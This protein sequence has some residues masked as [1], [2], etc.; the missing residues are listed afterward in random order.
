MSRRRTPGRTVALVGPDG[1]GKS[2]VVAAALEQLGPRGALVYMGINPCAAT[3][4][5]PTTRLLARRHRRRSE[6]TPEPV[7]GVVE[8]ASSGRRRR[9]QSAL[10]VLNLVLEEQYR[11]LVVA[12]HRRQ[13][14][15]VLLDRDFLVDHWVHE[16]TRPQDHGAV[17]RLHGYVLRRWYRPPDAV[18]CLEAP[19]AVLAARR[20]DVDPSELS[21][22]R[23]ELARAR[24]ELG[25][26]Q[27]DADRPLAA[28]I[29]DVL[30]VAD[31]DGLAAVTR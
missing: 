31:P 20:P 19:V 8:E 22:R 29:E 15:V 24:R 27:V 16:V 28:V 18:V 1:V 9:C 21:R 26:V 4:A 23:E 6:G 7:R 25:G 5:L 12:W 11:Q 10:L 2:T 3:V 17:R 14:R 30:A 13:G